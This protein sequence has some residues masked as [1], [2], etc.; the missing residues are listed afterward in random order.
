[1]SF[2]RFLFFIYFYNT[3]I[4]LLLP[5]CLWVPDFL[6]LNFS[7]P[8]PIYSIFY[9]PIWHST[10]LSFTTVLIPV[11]HTTKLT[12]FMSIMLPFLAVYVICS[13]LTMPLPYQSPNGQD[14]EFW[15]IPFFGLIIVS[16]FLRIH[17]MR[18]YEIPS[19]GCL[20]EC[21]TVLWCM[22]CSTA[23]SKYAVRN[24]Q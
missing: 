13:I 23:Q 5:L 2:C 17:F 4:S 1:M 16:V 6:F 9:L 18:T 19:S 15:L 8:F 20:T 21:C 11:A 12:H 10:Y 7:F 22:P 3:S 24:R 14:H